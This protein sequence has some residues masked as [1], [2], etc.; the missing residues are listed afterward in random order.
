MGKRMLD[1]HE[2]TPSVGRQVIFDVFD[3]RVRMKKVLKRRS[4][5]GEKSIGKLVLWV[6]FDKSEAVRVRNFFDR[7]LKKL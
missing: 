5:N 1:D 7:A 6:E 2:D 4:R 3:G